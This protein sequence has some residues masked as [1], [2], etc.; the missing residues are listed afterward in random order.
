MVEMVPLRSL[1]RYTGQR[2]M[3]GTSSSAAAGPASK[4]H[5]FIGSLLLGGKY[6]IV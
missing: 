4:V 6:I 1:V 2:Y 5:W 3:P